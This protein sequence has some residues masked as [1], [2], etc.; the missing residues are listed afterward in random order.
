MT[1][2]H[3]EL[4]DALIALREEKMAYVKLEKNSEIVDEYDEMMKPKSK[5]KISE[6][7][8]TRIT[9]A[10][11]EFVKKREEYTSQITEKN[12]KL[13]KLGDEINTLKELVSETSDIGLDRIFKKLLSTIQDFFDDQEKKISIGCENIC[14]LAL[15]RIQEYETSFE[16]PKTS[17][18]DKQTLLTVMTG[19]QNKCKKYYQESLVKQDEPWIDMLMRYYYAFENT[20]GLMEVLSKFASTTTKK[21]V[22]S[23]FIKDLIGKIKITVLSELIDYTNG[24]NKLLGVGESIPLYNK[25]E[26]NEFIAPKM[27]IFYLT[28]IPTE[29]NKTPTSLSSF[30]IFDLA[31]VP[32][33]FLNSFNFFAP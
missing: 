3:E 21:R 4:N 28:R 8:K 15:G 25:D 17:Y 7:E 30:L 5:K 2:Q 9:N 23:V 12:E 32:I 6:E 11:N 29:S 1:K 14:D 18:S 10:Y 27:P 20:F 19:L 22:Y 31:L 16:K 24:V 13:E 33:S 26:T